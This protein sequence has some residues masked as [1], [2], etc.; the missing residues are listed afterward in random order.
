MKLQT[1]L[2]DDEP[3]GIN[4]M[5]SLLEMNC[6][7]VDI[8]G[9]YTNADEAVEGINQ[10]HPQL[11]FLDIA[12]PVKSGFQMLK[13][14][15]ELN[16]EVIFVTAH[17][18]YMLDA[19]H[20]SAI[21]YLLKPIDDDLLIDAVTRASKRIIDKTGTKHLQNLINSLELGKVGQDMKL[22]IPS[23]KGFVVVDLNTI[24]FADSCGNYTNFYFTDKQVICS[25]KPLH[26]YE[27]ILH[28]SNFIRIHKS[29]LVN[30]KHIKEYVRGE[31]GSVIL[32]NGNKLDVSRRR[33]E[34]FLHRMK[35]FYKY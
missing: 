9:R 25:S 32:S 2:V 18:K 23:I 20:F 35:S 10:L 30:L 12:M 27:Q 24:L 5:Q 3:R 34:E 31:G 13:E 28:D 7:D 4:T 26:D 21:D 19:F 8:I 33:K 14:I 11:I 15:E 1:V 22:C 17:N 6:P 16:F 29:C